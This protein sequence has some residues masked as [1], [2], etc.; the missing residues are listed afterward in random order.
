VH[1]HSGKYKQL[2]QMA[3]AKRLTESDIGLQ[4]GK[5]KSHN[6]MGLGTQKK[7]KKARPTVV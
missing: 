5:I 1:N 3:K 4:Q 2:D 6:N 7:L